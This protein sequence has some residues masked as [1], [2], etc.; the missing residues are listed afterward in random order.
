MDSDL[1]LRL[2]AVERAL[3]RQRALA[4][5]ALAALLLGLTAPAS[6]PAADPVRAGEFQLVDGA[7]V[8]RGSFTL[9]SGL[10][11]S[12]AL[13]DEQGRKRWQVLLK[14]DEVFSYMRD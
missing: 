12:L 2:A 3:R 13:L 7:G 8:V 9:E 14:D 11:P 5:L 1:A 4:G 6:R 10:H